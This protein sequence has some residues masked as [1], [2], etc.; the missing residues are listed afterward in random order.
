MKKVVMYMKPT[1]P[2]CQRAAMLL[3]EKGVHYESINLLQQPE[4]R[5][6]MIERANGR[7]TVPQIFIGDTH[8][9]GCDDLEALEQKG[10]LDVLLAE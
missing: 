4:R 10:K 3:D 2:Y 6:E 9:G 8:V 5:D 7:T 1:C